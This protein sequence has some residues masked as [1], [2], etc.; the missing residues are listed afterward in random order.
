LADYLAAGE[1]VQSIGFENPAELVWR[2]QAAL[3]LLE[4]ERRDE[5]LVLAA[6]E[7]ELSR[8]WGA[9]GTLGSALHA[10]GLVEG[11]EAGEEHL[12]E[13]LAVLADSPNRLEQARVQVALGAAL[14]RS[15]SRSEARKHLR[16][17]LELAEWCGATSLYEQ[18]NDELAATGAHRRTVMLRGIDALTASEQRVAKMAAAGS[19][20]KEIAQGLFV[21]VKTV[22]MH[23]SRVYRKLELGSRTELAGALGQPESLPSA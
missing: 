1:A 12:R 4:L 13:A 11:G 8:R 2:S 17:A 3:A 23:L 10:L 21:T 20:N 19:S 16:D 22:E 14:R 18:A 7:V 5:A 15:N 6:E 9:P